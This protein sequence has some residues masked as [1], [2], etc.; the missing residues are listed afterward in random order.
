MTKVNGRLAG[1]LGS[2]APPCGDQAAA[3]KWFADC[4]P[5]R[6]NFAEEPGL[7]AVIAP[8]RT[9]YTTVQVTWL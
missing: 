2:R 9:K 3:S 4:V 6:N 1:P 7:F 8:W 5:T